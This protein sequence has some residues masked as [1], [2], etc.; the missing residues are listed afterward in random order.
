MQRL[1]VS[2]AVRPIY[3]SL[4]VKRLSDSAYLS[5]SQY[6]FL[7]LGPTQ[8]IQHPTPPTPN[9]TQSHTHG[10]LL[11]SHFDTFCRSAAG[12]P[13]ADA[14]NGLGRGRQMWGSIKGVKWRVWTANQSRDPTASGGNS[15]DKIADRCKAKTEPANG[16][17]R[18]YFRCGILHCPHQNF[19]GAGSLR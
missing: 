14:V 11:T 1:E 13:S 2:G 10:T 16:E 19:C 5:G 15:V 9:R 6:H 12:V 4:G 7:P 18:E 17:G 3:G 8:T